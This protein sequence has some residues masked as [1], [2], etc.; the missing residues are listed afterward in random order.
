MPETDDMAKPETQLKGRVRLLKWLKS[1]ENTLTGLAAQLGVKVPSVHGWTT[2]SRPAEKHRS[3]LSLIIGGK[4]SDW[5]SDEER[6]A[7]RVREKQIKALS[8]RA[9]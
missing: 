9:A 1:K 8:G 3:L 6:K 2:D 7:R 4:P 5:D